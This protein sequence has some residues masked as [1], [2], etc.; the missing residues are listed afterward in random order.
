M[1]EF[2]FPSLIIIMTK[3]KSVPGRKQWSLLA[4]LMNWK[5]SMMTQSPILQNVWHNSMKKK[6]APINFTFY[7]SD[8][9][10]IGDNL[11]KNFGYAALSQIYHELGIHTFLIN[12]QHHSKEQYDSNTIM[13]MLVYSRLL[14]PASKKSSYDSRERFFENTEY[15]LDDVYRCLS[16]LDKHRENLQIW[17]NDRIKKIYGR[18][19][20]LIYYDVTNYYFETD[21]QNDFLHKGVCKEH[22][23]NPIIQMGLFID[24]KG[25]PITYELFPGNTNDCLTYRP[26]LGRIK[27]QFDLGRVITVADKGMTTGDNI[28]YTINTP[29][30]DGYVFSMS[31]R[32]A[33][34]SLK[35][36]VL[37]D[38][39][40]EWLGTEY[41]RKS[42]KCPRTIQVTSVTGKKIKNRWMKNRLFSGVKNMPNGQK[43]N[44]KLL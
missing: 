23:P 38:E 14:F 44:G 42:R 43:Q 33:E 9:L 37:K 11:R 12:R 36:Y 25:I 39:G 26:N 29:T 4:G 21:E 17:M 32:G 22:R 27:K 7:D 30:H 15:S 1:D 35:D 28:W 24:N 34:K 18:D 41:K 13:K 3:L 10:R 6:Q 8:R 40:Y 31:I 2:V 19:T 5:N 16:F 20:S